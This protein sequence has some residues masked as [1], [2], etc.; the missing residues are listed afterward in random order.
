MAVHTSGPAELV[1]P[2]RPWSVQAYCY[3]WSKACIFRVLV[4][5]IIVRLRF[6]SNGRSD[7]SYTPS[8]GPVYIP[9]NVAVVDT[10]KTFIQGQCHINDPG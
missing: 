1:Q 7:E 6:F 9:T 5:P 8:A 2:L 3:L 4:G 10:F